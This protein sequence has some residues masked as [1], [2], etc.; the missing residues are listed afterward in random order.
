M[1]GLVTN[2]GFLTCKGGLIRDILYPKKLKFKRIKVQVAGIDSQWQIDLIDC[3][4]ISG[5]NYGLKYIFT[6][7]DVFSKHAWAI[8]IKNKEAKSCLQAFKS[9][10]N[11]SKRKPNHLYLDNGTF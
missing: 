9:I 6:C 1:Y 7:I 10:I 5:S 3:H 4:D 2:T 8:P 11:E